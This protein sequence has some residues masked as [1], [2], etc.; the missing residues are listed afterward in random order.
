M[1]IS[2]I[3]SSA[4]I[5]SMIATASGVSTKSMVFALPSTSAR[6]VLTSSTVLK[7]G[8][9]TTSAPASIAAGISQAESP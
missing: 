7:N 2:S 6:K 3:P 5:S 4:R 8:S 1:W 9:M